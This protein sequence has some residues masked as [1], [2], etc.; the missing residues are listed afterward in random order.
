MEVCSRLPVPQKSFDVVFLQLDPGPDPGYSPRF[1]DRRAT[2]TT[3]WANALAAGS[4]GLAVAHVQAEA[5]DARNAEDSVLEVAHVEA[6]AEEAPVHKD[7]A[8]KARRRRQTVAYRV[9][10]R[11]E[12][13]RRE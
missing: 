9:E 7:C 10:H 4:S 2:N 12:R 5:L 13:Q 6:G 1:F 8:A 11:Q 3:R